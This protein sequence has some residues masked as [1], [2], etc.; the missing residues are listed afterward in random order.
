MT[1][2]Y[3]GAAG[4]T[5]ILILLVMISIVVYQFMTFG[6]WKEALVEFKHD[7]VGYVQAC[8]SSKANGL[9]EPAKLPPPSDAEEA[10]ETGDGLTSRFWSYLGY[11][12]TTGE[13]E[14]KEMV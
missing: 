2:D 13:Q 7:P 9:P 8:Y 11:G 5:F 4:P 1:H 12:S 14:T 3:K 10:E 6:P